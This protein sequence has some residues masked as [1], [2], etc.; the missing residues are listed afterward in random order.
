MHISIKSSWFVVL[1]KSTIPL[2]RFCL[3]LLSH[4]LLKVGYWSFQWLLKKYL[5]LQF[6]QGLLPIFKDH[7]LGLLM[8]KI[9]SFTV[10]SCLLKYSVLLC[11]IIFFHLHSIFSQVRIAPSA[12][13][14]YC[15]YGIPF[16]M[17]SFFKIFIG[18]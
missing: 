7:L 15:L 18:I 17:L 3:F 14:C 1:L 13:C 10:L 16:L 6:N 11:L 2:L 5:S 9:L 4:L 12:L 8:L